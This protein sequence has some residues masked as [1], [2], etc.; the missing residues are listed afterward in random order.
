MADDPVLITD[1]LS[2]YFGGLR[3]VANV[4][5]AVT[6]QSIH[7]IIG[8]NGAGKTTLFNLITQNQQATSGSVIFRGDLLDGYTPDRV[9][10]AG[11]SRTYQ[12]I[13]LFRNI[14][15]IENLLVGMHLHLRSTWWGAAFNTRAT[16]D[17]EA[18]AQEEA[19]RLLAFVDLRGRGDILA[20]N[21]AYGEQRRLE[22]GRALATKPSLLLLDE[23][24]AGMNP[25]ET[26][27][28]M[29]FIRTVRATFG[30]TIILIEHQMRVVMTMS[31]RVS[32]LDHGVK[33]AEGTPAEVQADPA[34]IEAYL[35]TRKGVPEVARRHAVERIAG[36]AG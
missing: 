18:S 14:T 16:R 22:I 7:S 4:D 21:L 20:R 35:G 11:I 13:R 25:R 33:I 5:L 17:D 19:L 10:A 1:K 26:T 23:P 8:P 36:S 28:M 2:K 32:V 15:A 29:A 34:V 12:N 6:A 27:D 3:A 30:I 9:A 24:T 31:D